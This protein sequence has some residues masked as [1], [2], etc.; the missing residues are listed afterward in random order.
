[1]WQTENKYNH[2]MVNIGYKPFIFKLDLA[3]KKVNIHAKN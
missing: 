3:I 1:M 2:Q